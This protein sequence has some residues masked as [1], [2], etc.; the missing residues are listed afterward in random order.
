MVNNGWIYVYSK[1][2]QAMSRFRPMVVLLGVIC[3]LTTGK[4]G[5]QMLT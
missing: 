1:T 5:A 2:L 3:V 4:C